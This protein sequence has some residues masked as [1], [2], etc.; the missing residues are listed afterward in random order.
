VSRFSS[1]LQIRAGLLASGT[2]WFS[3]CSRVAQTIV[4]PCSAFALCDWQ[5]SWTCGPMG[6]P[7]LDSDALCG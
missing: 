6:S 5:M 3:A 2:L 1:A 4:P 7:W